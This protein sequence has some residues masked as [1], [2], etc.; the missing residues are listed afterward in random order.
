MQASDAIAGL[1]GKFFGFVNRNSET[2]LSEAKVAFND[3]QKRGLETLIRLMVDRRVPG[4]RSLCGVAGGSTTTGERAW[5]LAAI[6]VGLVNDRFWSWHGEPGT[7]YLRSAAERRLLALPSRYRTVRTRPQ[8]DHSFTPGQRL[9][10]AP[11]RSSGRSKSLVAFANSLHEKAR[12]AMPAGSYP[13]RR[14][15]VITSR[16]CAWRACAGAAH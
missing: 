16:G 13:V 12:A 15:T 4:F 5:L 8:I 10:L 6:T 1:L 7:A 14:R 2:D 3:R 9:L 11:I